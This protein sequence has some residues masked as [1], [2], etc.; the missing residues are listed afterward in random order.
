MLWMLDQATQIGQVVFCLDND[1]RGILGR[2]RLER[3]LK[4]HGEYEVAVELAENKDWNEDV[5]LM[6]SIQ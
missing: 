5:G 4:E 6:Q 3:I 2:E 1:E